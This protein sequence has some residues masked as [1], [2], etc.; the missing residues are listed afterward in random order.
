[1]TT[2][3]SWA[4]WL[5]GVFGIVVASFL[6]W[7]DQWRTADAREIEIAQLKRQQIEQNQALQAQIDDSAKRK[8][9]NAKLGEFHQQLQNRVDAIKGLK[10]ID[11]YRQ[12]QSD[13]DKSILDHDSQLL[14]DKIAAFVQEHFG[15]SAGHDLQQIVTMK[16][17]SGET[18]GH[19]HFKSIRCLQEAM[20]ILKEL[21]KK[22]HRNET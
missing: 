11:Y 19:Y 14:I 12:Y 18:E 15:W 20:K 8:S 13:Y 5:I 3:P 9:I 10:P 4:I 21:S 16:L 7:R 2:F 1:M 22:V 6:A 17:I